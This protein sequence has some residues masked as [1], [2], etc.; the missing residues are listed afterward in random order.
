[1]EPMM[2]PHWATPQMR[3]CGG[4]GTEW[5]SEVHLSE[6]AVDCQLCGSPLLGISRPASEIDL[7]FGPFLWRADEAAAA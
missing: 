7:V 4:C 3:L 1:M 6:E 5:Y 2:N